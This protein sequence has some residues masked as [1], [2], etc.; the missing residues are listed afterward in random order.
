VA[1]RTA[2]GFYPERGSVDES[3]LDRAVVTALGHIASFHRSRPYR[4]HSIVPHVNRHGDRLEGLSDEE[5]AWQVPG[6]RGELRARGF[7][8]DL[9]G[10]VFALVREAAERRLRQRHY[11]VQLIG[12][13]AL[14]NGM[15]AEMATGEGKTLTAT[16]PACTAALAGLPVHIITVNDYLARRDARWMAPVYSMLGLSV[17]HVTHGKTPDERRRAYRCDI[18]YCTN[19]E[20]VFDYLRDRLE[21]GRRPGQIRMRLERL[22]KQGARLDRLRL[23]GLCFGIVDEADSVLID[24]ARTPL[25]ISGRGDNSYEARLYEQALTLSETLESGEDYEIDFSKREIVLTDEGKVR[26]EAEADALGGFWKGR[27]RREDLVRKALTARYLY[28]RDKQYV[29]ADGKVQIVDEYTGRVMPG[30]SWEGGLHQLIEAKEGCDVTSRTEVLARISYQRFHRRYL[31]LAGMT[32]T[33]RE[34]ARE[35]W[36]VY[37]LHV[38]SIPTNRPLIRRALPPRLYRTAGEKWSAVV[39]R[40]AEL[41]AAERPVLVGTRTVADSQHLSR[42]LMAAGLPHR[43]LNA[44]Q[45]REEAEIIARAGRAGEITVATNMAG[46]GTDIVIP[47][48][49]AARG[50]LHVIAT[51]RHDARRIDR[52]LFGRCGRQGD[53]GTYEAFVSLEDELLDQHPARVFG[54][55]SPAWVNPD[56]ALGRWLGKVLFWNTQCAAERKYYHVRCQLLQLDEHMDSALAFTGSG[57]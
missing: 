47:E 17:D 52:Q 23:R 21:L 49:V 34:A 4:F 45:S 15:V 25:I 48:E 53:P 20:I 30:R 37:R 19:K 14:L 26:L 38:V 32:G 6:L 5:L 22:Y 51:E 40:I 42:L 8:L 44:L 16:L 43:V 50:G 10:H 3:G 29:V 54:I 36:S 18:T 28:S 39:E 46:R 57:E 24:E 33:A 55:L 35:L 1:L 11:D 41:N 9:V 31:A 12:G 7:T 56:S 2:Q 27:M 13:W